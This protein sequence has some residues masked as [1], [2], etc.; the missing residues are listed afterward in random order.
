MGVAP[1]KWFILR[2]GFVHVWSHISTSKEESQGINCY[3]VCKYMVKSFGYWKATPPWVSL[4]SAY[5]QGV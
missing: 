5:I 1:I 2:L 4:R 3:S